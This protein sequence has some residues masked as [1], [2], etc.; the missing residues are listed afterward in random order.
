M[1][2]LCAVRHA[3]V[4]TSLGGREIRLPS[5]VRFLV[6]VLG[7]RRVAERFGKLTFR[8]STARRAR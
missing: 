6:C 3:C 8:V 5:S 2:F 4:L 7:A 1:I